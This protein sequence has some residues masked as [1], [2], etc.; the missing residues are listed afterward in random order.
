[1]ASYLI[2]YVDPRQLGEED[3]MFKE[4]TYGEAKRRGKILRE[5]VKKGDFLF[6]HTSRKGKRIITAYYVVEKVMATEDAK[7]DNLIKYKLIKYKYENPHLYHEKLY[8]NDTIVFGN[9][10]Y[11]RVLKRPLILTTKILNQLSK[12]PRLNPNQTELAGITSALRN[13]KELTDKDVYFLLSEIEK[14]EE[15]SVLKDTFLSTSE[16]EQLDEKEIE[17]FVATNPTILGSDIKLLERQ[18]RL[19]SGKKIDLLLEDE[20]G[21]IVVEIKKGQIGKEAY[22]QVKTYLREI[23]KESKR[24]ARGIIICEDILPAFEEFFMDKIEKRE[25]EVY[26]YG[27]K[28]DLK[29][30]FSR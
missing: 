21:L 13:W 8:K 1:M 17:K 6:F 18:H 29:P 22:K 10:I 19:N 3:P 12:P 25:I 28:Y 30:L 5:K 11:S 23:R 16:V 20:R 9:P 15:Q 7:K 4:F 2:S 26:L 27:W 14:N 24:S